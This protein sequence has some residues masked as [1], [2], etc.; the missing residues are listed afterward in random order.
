MLWCAKLNYNYVSLNFFYIMKIGN[1]NVIVKNG[2]IAEEKV[3]CIVIHEFNDSAFFSN[4]AE[5][6]IDC[7]MKEGFDLYDAAVQKQPL[8]LGHVM[9]TE[10]GLKNI[11]LAHVSTVNS[12]KETQFKVIFDAIL[13]LLLEAE[14][15]EMRTIAIPQLGVGFLGFLTPEQ[16]ASAIFGAVNQ[17]AIHYPDSNIK[18]IRLVICYSSTVPAETVL[19]KQSFEF[20]NEIGEKQFSFE[21]WLEEMVA[22]I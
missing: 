7:G 16:S 20:E 12:Q 14:K 18:E 21:A 15:Q 1:I 19:S 6:I 22:R 8:P 13:M 4:I 3:D 9:I 17:F 11:K 10:S 5:D 2:N